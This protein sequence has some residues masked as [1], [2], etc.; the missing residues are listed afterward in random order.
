MN[1]SAAKIHLALDLGT[2]TLAGC[3]LDG[4]GVRLAVAQAPNPQRLLG[5]DVLRR[6]EAARDGQATELQR[7][8]IE[9]IDALVQTLC[10]TAGV[11]RENI[12]SAAAAANS[13]VTLL[14]RRL[15]VETLLRPP[16]RPTDLSGAWFDLASAGVDGL[17]PLYLFPLAGGFVGGDLVAFLYGQPQPVAPTLYID[18]G[19]NAE[20]A[21]FAGDRWW[22][23][24]AAA[25]PAFEGEGI[26]AGMAF[27]PG[28]ICGVQCEADRFVLQVAGGGVPCG[29]CGSGL[30]EAIA[31][32]RD[33]GLLDAQGTFVA[34]DAV[35]TN[36]ARYLRP[37][38]SGFALQLYRDARTEILLTQSDVRNFQLAKAAVRAGV[39]CLLQKAAVA[40]ETI[41]SVVLTGAFG[42]S[43]TS[44][45]L[46][47]VAMLPAKM[48]DKVRFEPGGAL[49]GVS[50]LLLQESGRSEVES[51]TRRL[52]SYPLSGT[53]A[54]ES[55]FIEAINF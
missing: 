40:G 24:S 6:L 46:K 15:P 54:F 12:S 4:R 49:S 18:I 32:A 11:G 51:F 10:S 34:P 21:L 2:T 26:A 9:G 55:A 28:A 27:A 25:G 35:T 30:V 20:L 39:D 13:A 16:Y 42:F 31:A 53:P 14:L 45:T 1:L 22:V 8:L 50:R 7:L 36:L 44:S 17:P 41:E 47:K 37:D 33:G 3:L 5:A 23:T 29:I 43:L 52:T 19:T 48:I 38:G